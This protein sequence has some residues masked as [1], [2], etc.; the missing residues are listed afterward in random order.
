V[1]DVKDG[2]AVR[3]PPAKD[4]DVPIT[5]QTCERLT[6]GL[7]RL[8]RTGRHLGH[9][10]AADLYGDLPPT[11]WALL[12]PLEKLGEQRCG[13][14]ADQLGVDVSVASRQVSALE[15]AG[16]VLRRPDPLDGR[17]SLIS[18]SGKGAAALT[19]IRELRGQWARRALDGWSEDDARRFTELLERL[20]DDLDRAGRGRSPRLRAAAPLAG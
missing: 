15:R 2:C 4:G 8:V 12:G 19:R 18:L 6:A 16:Y 13:A 7:V 3:I 14:L 20:A 1:D 17:A 11:G 10:A 9:T 5:R